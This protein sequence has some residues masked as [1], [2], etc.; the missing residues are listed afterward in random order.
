MDTSQITVRQYLKRFREHKYAKV[1]SLF[2]PFCLCLIEVLAS[3]SHVP[4]FPHKS[5]LA[6]L[7]ESIDPKQ[8]LSWSFRYST[9]R[10]K[11]QTH[12]PISGIKYNSAMKIGAITWDLKCS[13]NIL[14]PTPAHSTLYVTLRFSFRILT[15][16]TQDTARKAN[17]N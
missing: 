4:R 12:K 13:P 16:S 11:N 10:D 1:S 9:T 7:Q 2:L 3:T 15:N 17:N 6:T 5:V 14:L 8:Y